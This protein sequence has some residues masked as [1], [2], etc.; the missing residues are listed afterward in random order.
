MFERNLTTYTLLIII[1][2]IS[3][4]ILSYNIAITSKCFVMTIKLT[5]DAPR[6]NRYNL[7]KRTASVA[8]SNY[9]PRKKVKRK[10]D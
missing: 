6:Q 1:F 2:T 9:Y 3:R 4:C 8:P 5:R 7:R 10:S